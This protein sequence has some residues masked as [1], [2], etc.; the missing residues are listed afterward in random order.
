MIGDE[1]EKGLICR[2]GSLEVTKNSAEDPVVNELLDAIKKLSPA[3]Q[4]SLLS[5]VLDRSGSISIG[6]NNVEA[7]TVYQ[8]N[9]VE[10]TSMAGVLEAVAVRIGAVLSKK[11]EG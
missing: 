11:D 5:R 10:A 8:F 1:Y 7:D 2:E 4:A 3:Q 6:S 9:L